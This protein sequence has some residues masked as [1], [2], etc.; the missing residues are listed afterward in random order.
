[1]EFANKIFSLVC[2]LMLISCSKDS[3]S[4][5]IF[6]EASPVLKISTSSEIGNFLN[7]INTNNVELYCKIDGV[8]TLLTYP[9]SDNY[10]GY[11]VFQEPPINEKLIKISCYIGGNNNFEDTY[12]KWN[13]TD[14]DTLS[15]EIT[16]YETGSIAIK[17]LKFN[18]VSITNNNENGI[19]IV[20][21]N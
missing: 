20:T 13:E 1:M 18:S 19:Y 16:R 5:N 8:L 7:T 10:S 21:K 6:I 9:N 4:E 14:I 17:S 3:S 15:Y 11:S 12:I 2:I